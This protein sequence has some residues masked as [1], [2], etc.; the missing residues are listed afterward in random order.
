MMDTVVSIQAYYEGEAFMSAVDAAFERMREV[1]TMFSFHKPESELSI[2][3]QKGCIFP[4][5]SFS[6]L[7]EFASKTVSMSKGRFDPSFAV[8]HRAYGFYNGKPRLPSDSE[9]ADLM[10]FTGWGKVL[11]FDNSDS[12]LKIASG[13]LLDLGG[14]AGGFAVT[15]AADELRKRGCKVFF[16]DDGGDLY[17][18]GI[19]PDG[20]PW[21]VGVSDPRNNGIMATIETVSPLAVSTSGDYERFV[22]VD[23]KKYHHIFDVETGKPTSW[24][25]SVTVVA[26]EPRDAD[27][28]STWLFTLPP[29]EAEAV[30]REKSIPALFLTASGS[31]WQSS[32]AAK[33]FTIAAQ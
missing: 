10:N 14:I 9:L 22:E 2:L 25:T 20:S 23:G 24:Y 12:S 11:S 7:I 33:Y 28:L 15:V 13:A 8:F 30:C 16:I 26:S 19:K 3:N 17:M 5:A 4:S 6:E 21:K 1:E 31:L 29:A 27:V 32:T 18:E